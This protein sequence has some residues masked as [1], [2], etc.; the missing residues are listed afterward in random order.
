MLAKKRAAR[1]L[2][3]GTT[4]VEDT[5]EDE[6]EDDPD[7]AWARMSSGSTRLDRQSPATS[8]PK[9]SGLIREVSKRI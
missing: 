1:F 5:N 2:R 9:L 7:A 3:N 6:D 8:G 4:G